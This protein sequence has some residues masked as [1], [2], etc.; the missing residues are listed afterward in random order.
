[1]ATDRDTAREGGDERP[2]A[3]ARDKS[4]ESTPDASG[5]STAG[6]QAR[7]NQEDESPG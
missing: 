1:M 6:D 4:R 2:G 3:S 5:H 7:R